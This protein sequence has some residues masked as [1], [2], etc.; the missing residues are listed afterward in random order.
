LK[1]LLAA[2]AILPLACT[3]PSETPT[4]SED[5][6]ISRDPITPASSASASASPAAPFSKQQCEALQQ[7]VQTLFTTGR[8]CK[9][10]TECTYLWTTVGLPGQCGLPISNATMPEVKKIVAEFQAR[11]CLDVLP[12]QPTASCPVPPTP[13]CVNGQ[14]N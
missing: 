9:A 1:R 13:A 2:V 14:C 10:S 5:A 11:R 8:S 6:S 3:K 4:Q 7:K 12:P